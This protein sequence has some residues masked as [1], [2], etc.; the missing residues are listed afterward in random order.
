MMSVIVLKILPVAAIHH[1]EA[2]VLVEQREAFL[3]RFDRLPEPHLARHQIGFAA[4]LLGDV[5]EV[6]QQRARARPPLHHPVPALLA[7]DLDDPLI[8]VA[9]R[10]I[11]SRPGFD[12]RVDAA[13]GL[14]R[15]DDP[16]AGIEDGEPVGKLSMLSTRSPN[17]GWSSGATGT[18]AL[19]SLRKTGLDAR[20]ELVGIDRLGKSVG[21]AERPRHL[22]EIEVREIGRRRSWR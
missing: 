3:E 2:I 10:V 19:R 15:D 17:S 21:G 7:G 5:D 12:E 14:V 22:E 6:P 13:I 16:A 1:D 20:D 4:L 18:T 8:V 9:A 11:R